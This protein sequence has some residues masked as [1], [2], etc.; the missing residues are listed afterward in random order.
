MDMF[1]DVHAHALTR[2]EAMLQ[3]W[4]VRMR[5]ADHDSLFEKGRNQHLFEPGL[6]G[7]AHFVRRLAQIAI[8]NQDNFILCDRLGT[9]HFRNC[10]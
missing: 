8:R 6:C 10:I 9:Y 3:C 4:V 1:K 5:P 2:D 7:P